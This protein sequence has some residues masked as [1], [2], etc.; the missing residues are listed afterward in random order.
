MKNKYQA[1][2]NNILQIVKV[3]LLTPNYNTYLTDS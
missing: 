1:S 3:T 2:G